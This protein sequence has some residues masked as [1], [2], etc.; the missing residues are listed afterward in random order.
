M[1]R[2]LDKIDSPADLKKLSPEEL[3]QLAQEIREEIIKVVSSVGGHLASSLGAV[4]LAIG[5]HYAL[6]TPKDV[7]IWDVGHQAYAHKL[8]TGR[9][10]QFKSLRQLGGISGFPNKDESVYDIFTTG[11]GSTSISTALGMAKAR[12]LNGSNERIVV[13]I[14]DASLGGGMAFEALNHAGHLNSNLTVILNDNEMSISP[15]VGALSGYL[16]RVITAPIYNRIRG[17]VEALLKRVPR[18]GFHLLRAVQRLEEGLKNL[19]VPGMLFEELGFRYFGP[20][21]GHD[22]NLII[23]TLRNVSAIIGP[24]LI[25]T[26][27]KK[28]KGYPHAESVPDKFHGVSSFDV[29][30]GQEKMFTPLDSPPKA[31]LTG[32]TVHPPKVEEQTFTEAFSEELMKLAKEDKKIVAITAA[33]PEGTGLDK[34][35]KTFSERFFDVGMAE[36]H[37]VAFGAGLARNGF[38]PVVAVYSTFLQR[39]Y[40]QIVHDVCLQDL[41]VILALDRAGLVGEDGPTHHGVFDLAYLRHLPHLTVMAPKDTNELKKM[42]KFALGHKGPIAIRYPRGTAYPIP[43]TQPQMSDIQLGKAEILK[44]GKDAAIVAVGSMV[45]PSLEAADILF[46]EGVGVTVINVRFI[47]PID[48]DLFKEI[49]LKLKRIITVEEGVLEGGFGSSILEFMEQEKIG[50]VKIERMGLPGEFIP[51]GKRE[52]LLERYNLTSEQI[53]KTIKKV[54]AL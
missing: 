25:H 10:K 48:K 12:D 11:H 17:D 21:D 9:R 18:F 35:A 28:G 43:H 38:R 14:G 52:L 41:G 8:L 47:T 29:D 13:V 36:Q 20:I 19:L 3:P 44:E 24:T 54:I 32:F 31:G 15:T 16:N 51:H 2:L 7:L 4:E 45:L 22:I 49:F 33:M 26:V 42:L 27:T 46:S 30:T 1:N 53:A 23:S 6:D 40:D 39:A 50:G 5:L 37:A 34:F